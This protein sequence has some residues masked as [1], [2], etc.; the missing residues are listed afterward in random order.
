MCTRR[1][2][3]LMTFHVFQT[4]DAMMILVFCKERQ[5]KCYG[6]IIQAQAMQINIKCFTIY[7]LKTEKGG[8]AGVDGE[9]S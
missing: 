7:C 6:M 9:E 5:F 1:K 8:K 3:W 2:L 4:K